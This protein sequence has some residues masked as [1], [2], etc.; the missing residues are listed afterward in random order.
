[1]YKARDDTDKCTTAQHHADADLYA[2]VR[3]A[4]FGAFRIA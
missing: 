4:L 3:A 1:M 2:K